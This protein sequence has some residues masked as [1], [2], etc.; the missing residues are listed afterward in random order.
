MTNTLYTNNILLYS[1]MSSHGHYG[2]IKGIYFQIIFLTAQLCHSDSIKT[3]AQRLFQLL[4]SAYI[5]DAKTGGDY[6]RWRI[7][8]SGLAQI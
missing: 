4:L 3:N 7:Y 8:A 1:I 2:T 5:I 6:V